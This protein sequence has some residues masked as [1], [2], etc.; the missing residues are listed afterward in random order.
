MKEI[1]QTMFMK[2]IIVCMLIYSIIPHYAAQAYVLCGPGDTID[3]LDGEYRVL[4]NV[5]GADTNQ[6]IDVYPDS[7]Y[8]S[9]IYSEH[10]QSSVA[11]YPFILKGCHWGGQ[12]C[13]NN[14]GMPVRVSSIVTA[15][16]SWDI[17]TAGVSGTWNASY[18]SW[19]STSGG[20]A[21]DAAELMIWIDYGGGAWPGGSYQ[22]TVSIG[23][24]NW[25][26]Y[27]ASPWG[28]WDHYIAYRLITPANY[29]SLD[30][31]DFIDDSVSRGF[32]S[33]LWYMDNMEAGFEIWRDGEG[34]TTNSFSGS[35]IAIENNPPTVSITSPSNG[36][37][38][39]HGDDITINAD[40]SDSDG[41]VTRVEF[42]ED[43]TKLGEDTISPYSCTWYDVPTGCYSLTA[44][45][46]DN[47]SD[48]TT[49]S[50]VNIMVTYDDG[51]GMILREW[52]YGIPGFL[53]SNLTLNLNYPD[54]PTGRELITILEGPT[55]VADYYGTRIRGYLH[56]VTSGDYTFWIASDNNSE[57]WLS[58]NTNPANA[59]LIACVSGSHQTDP[60]Q[61]D[62][63]TEQQSPTIS[64]TAGHKYYIEVLHKEHNS[65]DN[66][67]VAWEGP[68]IS[69]EVI[70]GFYLSPWIL[71]Y[72]DIT[73]DNKVNMNDLSEFCEI[74]WLE[75][76]CNKTK[77]LDLNDDCI[78]NFYE[79]CFFAQNW[80]K[81]I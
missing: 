54:N 66:I 24:F 51:R 2:V 18:E 11:S 21:P 29:V 81:E 25:D 62:K 4:N 10:D 65:S 42:Y 77:Q 36:V 73:Y 8:F 27:H 46:T 22:G 44:K 45:A 64:L 50:T 39:N 14:S 6:C 68:G 56:P 48:K 19:F 60:R 16:F 33:P 43:S 55:N 74:W 28:D 34:L 53:V 70:D 58:T 80:L 57:L 79:F 67:A 76:D 1:I 20:T 3:V 13:T 35:V 30:F 41:F 12:N 32:I 47:D 9:V 63:Y 26:V 15:P 37:R 71:L 69:Q 75:N 23:G 17:N 72:G 7:T 31:K 38:F 78:I 61:W 40:A 52:W 59:T 49:S 5:W